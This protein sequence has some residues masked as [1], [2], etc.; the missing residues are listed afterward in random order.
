[1]ATLEAEN[2]EGPDLFAVRSIL[3]VPASNPRAIAKARTLSADLVILDLEDAVKAEDKESA[4]AAAVGATAEPWPMPVAIRINV[5]TE[6]GFFDRMPHYEFS[7]ADAEAVAASGADF[8]VLPKAESGVDDL[9]S[10]ARKRVLA[11]IETPLSVMML[12]GILGNRELAGLIVGTNDLAAGLRLP[13]PE[14]R[15][16][17]GMALQTIVCGARSAGLPVWDGVYNA[18]DDLPGFEAECREGRSLGFDGKSLIHPTQV[19]P[20]NAIFSPTAEEIARATRLVEAATGG[21]ERFE[22]EMIESMHVEEARSLL[23]RARH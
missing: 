10:V 18:I 2:D 23:A 15:Q 6:K 3:F 20:C 22:G 19:G 17:L 21:A 12:Q 9:A 4:R 1:M 5:S 13:G 16:S 8:V 11:M 14:R 7:S